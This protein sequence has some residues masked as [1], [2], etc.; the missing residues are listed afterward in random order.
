MRCDT[1]PEAI[2]TGARVTS[3][4]ASP[5]PPPDY[6]TESLSPHGQ[7]GHTLMDATP[8]T[9]YVHCPETAKG[10]WHGGPPHPIFSLGLGLARDTTTGD[11][12]PA[13]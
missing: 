7:R 10:R 6:N 4:F 13:T 5:A 12:F 8:L 11:V 3:W 1:E 9:P 2:G